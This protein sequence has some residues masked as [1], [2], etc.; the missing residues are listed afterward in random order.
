M[1]EKIKAA[2]R[3]KQKVARK[4]GYFRNSF[5][6]HIRDRS[7]KNGK[8]APEE[9]SRDPRLEPENRVPEKGL[10]TKRRRMGKSALAHRSEVQRRKQHGESFLPGGLG[11]GKKTKFGT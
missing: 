6:I 7:A 10:K 9:T 5:L 4:S 11:T 3:A 1:K 8:R 2:P